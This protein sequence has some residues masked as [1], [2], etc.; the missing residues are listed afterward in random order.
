MIV[1]KEEARSYDN[2]VYNVTMRIYINNVKI[3]STGYTLWCSSVFEYATRI[4]M[5]F[6][7]NHLSSRY[8]RLYQ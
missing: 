8:M 7:S 1:T 4:M 5:T 2:M 3:P 6:H